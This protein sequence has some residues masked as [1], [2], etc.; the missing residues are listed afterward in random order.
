MMGAFIA[1]EGIDGSG[2]TTVAKRLACAARDAGH[3]VILTREPGGTT[4]G[5]EIRGMLL[6]AGASGTSMAPAT[7]ALLFAASRAQLVTDVIRPALADGVV[8]IIDRFVDSSLAYQWGGRGL[9]RD[10]IEATQQLATGGV[11]PDLKLLFDLPVK[12]SLQRRMADEKHINRLDVETIEFHERVRAAYH[13]LALE[14]DRRWR[15]ID[16]SRPLNDVWRD[17]VCAVNQANILSRPIA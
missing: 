11:R 12:Q 17:V 3:G 7:E 15:V 8:V 9:E 16:A 1:L 6:A 4:I 5:E 10:D 2:K 14:D 13:T